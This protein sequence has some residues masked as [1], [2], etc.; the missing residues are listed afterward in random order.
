MTALFCDVVGSTTMA[1]RLD[2][3]EWAEIMNEAFELFRRPVV[4]YEGTVMRLMGDAL[5]AL[6]GAPSAHEDDPQRAVLAGLAIVEAVAPLRA[7]LKRDRDWDFNV[8]VGI[9][10]GPVVVGAVVASVTPEYTALGDAVNVA[11]RMEQG[12]LPGTVQ[13]S[14]A[15]HR[16]VAP[17]FDCEPLGG[18]DIRGRSETVEAYRVIGATANPGRLRG[19]PGVSA[20]LVG[21]QQELALLKRAL[22]E[23][24]QGRGQVVCLIGEAGLGKSRMLEELKEFWTRE[25][26]SRLWVASHGVAYESG[27][28]YGLFQHRMREFFGVEIEDSAEVVH[29]KVAAGMRA[30][31][32]AEDQIRLCSIAAERMIAARAL[33]DAPDVPAEAI[34]AEIRSQTY[35]AWLKLAPESPVVMVFDDLHWADNAS[36]ELLEHLLRLTREVPIL[37]LLAFRPE[38]QSPAWQLKGAAESGYPERYTEVVLRPLDPA[39][40]DNMVSAL[41]RIADLPA[42]LRRLIVR[43]TE[44]N[45][46]FVEEIVRTLIEQGL[47]VR[48]ADGMHW[49]STASVDDV[50]LPDSLQALLMS[51]IDRLDRETRSTLQLAAVIGRSFYY[52]ILRAISERSTRLDAHLATLALVE[53]VLEASQD[54][55]LVYMFKHELA[56]DAA[57]GSILNRKKREFHR[58]VAEAIEALFPNDPEENSH[59]L[60]QHFEAAGDDA[61]AVRYYRMAAETAA[62]VSANFEAASHYARAIDAAR[63]SRAPESEQSELQ[64]RRAALLKL[65]A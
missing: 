11:A 25:H 13:I 62:A 24:G 64:S 38:R 47:V 23:V 34:K 16:A 28:P 29:A 39:E 50:T 52:R 41:L 19:V 33:H 54:P 37:F 6:F 55:E 59:R 60:A 43:K 18:I 36:G 65:S 31:G 3:E 46:Y 5:L 58:R 14:G 48:S 56:R 4:R 45:P 61:R 22:G 21:R 57:Y 30:Q 26:G 10:T 40:T 49:R 8:R 53:L 1:E 17:L 44:G 2:P 42:E 27:R 20:P 9:N 32:M 63:R 35:G 51:R 15:T 12:A 7:R